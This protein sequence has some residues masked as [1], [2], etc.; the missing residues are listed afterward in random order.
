VAAR[1]LRDPGGV[2]VPDATRE[3]ILARQDSL[4]KG[5]NASL[6]NKIYDLLDDRRRAGHTDF[7]LITRSEL[8]DCRYDPV[9]DLH[10]LRFIQLDQGQHYTHVTDGVVFATGYEQHVPRFIESI[11]E[12][13]D[14]DAQG[15]YRLSPH[16][17]IDGE[18]ASIFVQNA[19]SHLHG[20]INPDLGMGCYRNSRILEG[21]TGIR[22]YEVE[23]DTALQDFSVPD[24]PA[25]I[26]VGEN[27]R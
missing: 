20:L 16:Y 3:H 25:F 4:Y 7:R 8:A 23:R 22:H 5:I 19:A 26:K 14:W 12:R 27:V 11:R 10:H 9:A 1:R 17:A 15:R 18:R 6:I 2:A 21:L 13:I 24:D